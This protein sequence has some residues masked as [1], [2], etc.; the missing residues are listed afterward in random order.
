MT[1]KNPVFDRVPRGLG[2]G[3]VCFIVRFQ[4]QLVGDG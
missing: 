2:D 3:V 1:M 4:V